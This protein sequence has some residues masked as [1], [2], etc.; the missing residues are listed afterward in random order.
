M[1]V[2]RKLFAVITIVCANL[3]VDSAM[4][5]EALW[6]ESL[7]CA[8]IEPSS[9]GGSPDTAR[10]VDLADLFAELDA[11]ADT[12][13]NFKYDFNDPLPPPLP[14]DSLAPNCQWVEFEGYFR[15]VRYHSFRG[16]LVYNID[17]HYLAGGYIGL[18]TAHF[19]VENW[20]D[21]NV[22]SHALHNKRI[23]IRARVYDQCLAEMQYDRRR[24]QPGFRF[25]GACH[26]G[27]NTGMILTD[28]EVI[29]VLSPEKVIAQKPD[30]SD[31]LGR[32]VS[33]AKLR[34]PPAYDREYEPLI[35]IE[36][37]PQDAFDV[38]RD[39]LAEVQ[40][41]VEAAIVAEKSRKTSVSE[42][43]RIENIR[44]LYAHPDGRYGYLNALPN[45]ASIDAD[46][47]AIKFF[48][49]QPFGEWSDAPR[50]WHGY[51]CVALSPTVKWPVAEIDADHSIDAFVCTSVSLWRD[52]SGD[53]W[54]D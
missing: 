1:A 22:I 51:G 44:S 15:P 9:S 8:E 19:W 37:L 3:I 26:Y 42:D 49:H 50:K 54:R 52:D 48:S 29:E 23:R 30:L 6:W 41:G 36:D 25:G 17:D 35:T 47:V 31:V 33:V 18:R 24:N 12:Y 21:P 7:V 28:A 11:V 46:K 39:W 40:A 2:L 43:W 4:A 32:P 14:K 38:V 13:A 16:Q 53:E 45:F 10:A 27:E 34:Y 5:E 20:N